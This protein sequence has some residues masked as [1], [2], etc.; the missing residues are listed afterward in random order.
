MFYVL[1]FQNIFTFVKAYFAKQ[2]QTVFT[3]ILSKLT[4][5]SSSHNPNTVDNSKIF[6]CSCLK[7]AE[8]QAYSW[9]WFANFTHW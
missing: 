7:T 8:S 4:L 3:L 2:L 9:A 5:N 6:I 1:V